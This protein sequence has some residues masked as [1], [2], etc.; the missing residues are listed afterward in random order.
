MKDKF[1]ELN[2]IIEI[3]YVNH[4]NINRIFSRDFI[5][6][7]ISIGGRGIGKT[8]GVKL[9]VG[10]RNINF[11]E[12]FIYVRRYKDEINASKTL[13]N[14]CYSNVKAKGFGVKGAYEYC[15]GD[16]RIGYGCA[17]SIQ[18]TLK[19]GVDF[20]KVTTLVYDEATIKR[21]GHRRYLPNE[22]DDLLELISTVF[23]TRTNYKVIILGNNLDLFNPFFEYFDVPKFENEYID[24]ERG[25]YC[26][27]CKNNPNLIKIEENTPLYKLTKGTQ[28]HEYHYG[29]EVL[30]SA[31]AL[32]G[33]KNNN[34]LFLYRLLYNNITL[35]IYLNDSRYLFV[36]YREKVIKDD[37][38]MIIMENNK[39]N[40]LYIKALRNLNFYK[41]TRN[42]YFN[43]LI[44]Y[45]D[46]KAKEILDTIIDEIE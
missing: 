42:K 40:Y 23:R 16:R 32:L 18:Q 25:L 10:S 8:T 28:Y 7:I 11:K 14:E 3:D 19:S 22:M 2:R 38:T 21:G 5:N 41:I 17:L 30:I 20:S 6:F 35:N 33:I 1:E 37:K 34:S 44:Y 43:N 24:K 26:E 29:N 4:W 31:Q 46:N 15:V 12:E 9:Y 13:F 39:P 36:E 27:Y 45:N